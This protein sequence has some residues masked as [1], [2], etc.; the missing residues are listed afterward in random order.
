ML[1][2]SNVATV[3]LSGSA[4]AVEFTAAYAYY[5]LSNQS[6]G[7]MYASIGEPV[8]EAEGTYTINP[9]CDVRI[10]GGMSYGKINVIGTGKLMV[11]A[12][13]I[14]ECPINSANIGGSDEG[15]VKTVNGVSPD[16]KGNVDIITKNIDNIPVDLTGIYNTQVIGYDEEQGKL[17]PMN[18]VARTET[19]VPSN[20]NPKPWTYTDLVDSYAEEDSYGR[21]NISPAK[22]EIS[23]YSGTILFSRPYILSEFSKMTA[24]FNITYGMNVSMRIYLSKTSDFSQIDA[25][26]FSS[27]TNS[28]SSIDVTALKGYYY[29]KINLSQSHSIPAGQMGNY[30]CY[31][32]SLKFI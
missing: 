1:I 28:E 27:Q 14:A 25:E 18:V 10:P 32:D 9:G 23:E 13:N 2:N 24:K 26:L 20:E 30:K 3:D 31:V 12:Q 29:I 21:P 8:T 4:E 5:W 7:V 15:S 17:V 6:D 16:D 19:L 22:D 11:I